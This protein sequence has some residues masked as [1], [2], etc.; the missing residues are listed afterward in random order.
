M[1]THEIKIFVI[2]S[3]QRFKDAYIILI[4]KSRIDEMQTI[5]SPI[6]NFPMKVVRHRDGLLWYSIIIL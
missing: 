4:T 5:K 3:T 1:A 6:L 2:K